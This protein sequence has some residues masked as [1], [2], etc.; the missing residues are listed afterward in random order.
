[1]EPT[2]CF[3]AFSLSFTQARLPTRCTGFYGINEILRLADISLVVY[4]TSTVLKATPSAATT[5][6]LS[7]DL[8]FR[9]ISYCDSNFSKSMISEKLEIAVQNSCAFCWCI[10]Q[11]SA[12]QIT[13]RLSYS[14]WYGLRNSA[15][16]RLSK[17][18][19]NL[20]NSSRLML[21]F[22]KNFVIWNR[23]QSDNWSTFS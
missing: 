12:Q 21:T 7:G 10:A 20:L 17:S 15:F 3:Y 8:P 11:S 1:M 18:Y 6:F 5:G 23:R 22:R 19:D 13:W 2:S 14:P 4:V 9:Q 16:P